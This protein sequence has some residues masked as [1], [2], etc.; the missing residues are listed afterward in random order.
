MKILLKSFTLFPNLRKAVL[1]L[2]HITSLFPRLYEWKIILFINL[3]T[4]DTQ[5]KI[6]ELIILICIF[7]VDENQNKQNYISARLAKFA[8][9]PHIYDLAQKWQTP[10]CIILL[11]LSII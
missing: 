11:S 6:M 10:L 9:L 3:L 7:S 5:F 4:V 8:K 1:F 2:Y